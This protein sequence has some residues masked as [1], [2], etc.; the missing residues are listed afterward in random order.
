[1]GLWFPSVPRI[2]WVAGFSLALLL[3]NLIDV[4][5]SLRRGSNSGSPW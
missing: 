3:I 2:V 4:G 1:M 5:Q